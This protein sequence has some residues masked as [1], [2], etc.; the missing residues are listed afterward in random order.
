L[1]VSRRT[2]VTHRFGDGFQFARG[3]WL[4]DGAGLRRTVQKE[5][6]RAF[7]LAALPAA[8]AGRGVLLSL[9]R[10]EPQWIPYYICF[11]AFNYVGMLRPSR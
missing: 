2:I 3:Q 8:A 5:G 11:V 1:D 10:G 9:L 7:A 6:A 4:A